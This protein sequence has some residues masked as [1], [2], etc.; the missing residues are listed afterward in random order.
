MI[1][2]EQVLQL[3]GQRRDGQFLIKMNYFST[4]SI[5]ELRDN[6]QGLKK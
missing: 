6:K 5:M 1:G 2:T 3:W 4:S